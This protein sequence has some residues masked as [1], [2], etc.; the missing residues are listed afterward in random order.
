MHGQW[1]NIKGVFFIIDVHSAKQ[2]R[3][4]RGSVRECTGLMVDYTERAPPSLYTVG[5][6]TGR[7][8]MGTGCGTNVLGA[9][10]ARLWIVAV[11]WSINVN[12]STYHDQYTCIYIYIDRRT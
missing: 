7:G 5:R 10:C 12:E 11:K 3:L 8:G 1:S 4:V 2:A 9:S 6:G